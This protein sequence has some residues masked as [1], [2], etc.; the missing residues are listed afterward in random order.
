M[1]NVKVTPKNASVTNNGKFQG[2]GTSL[3]WWANRMGYS[4]KLANDA[5]DLFFNSEKGIGYNIMRY[6]IGG[7]DDP[8]H[9]HITRTD[10]MIPG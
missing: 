6:N 2:W 1:G 10:S 5:A 8:T 4:E 3:I 7:G 9:H